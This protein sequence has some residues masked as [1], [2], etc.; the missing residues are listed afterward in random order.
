MLGVRCVRAHNTG[1]R[2][3]DRFKRPTVAST[4]STTIERAWTWY[5][6]LLCNTNAKIR[7]TVFPNWLM[8]FCFRRDQLICI[9]VQCHASRHSWKLFS[10]SIIIYYLRLMY[11]TVVAA[12]GMNGQNIDIYFPSRYVGIFIML[13]SLCISWWYNRLCRTYYVIIVS[14]N[15]WNVCYIRRLNMEK[16]WTYICWNVGRLT[17]CPFI[18]PFDV[19]KLMPR[20]L[21]HFFV[22]HD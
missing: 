12:H 4:A 14:I 19:T 9:S 16:K 11:M 10:V 8:C 15:K 13:L 5:I 17:G 1:P 3:T 6:N 18:H 7:K 21:V 22:H 2:V 20:N